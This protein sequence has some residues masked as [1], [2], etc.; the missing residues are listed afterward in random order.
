MSIRSVSLC[1]RMCVCVFK[2]VVIPIGPHRTHS[3]NVDPYIVHLW[4]KLTCFSPFQGGLWRRR[5]RGGGVVRI[6]VKA[7]VDISLCSWLVRGWG[8]S[9]QTWGAHN[10]LGPRAWYTMALLGVLITHCVCVCVWEGGKES[11][12]R[13]SPRRPCHTL[14]NTSWGFGMQSWWLTRVIGHLPP[15]TH[16]C[17][18]L[19]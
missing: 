14:C 8:L 11:G 7:A 3:P 19:W 18:R 2:W 16:T 5:R 6:K 4:K 13:R 15:D 9:Y 12:W 17:T 1:E 10:I